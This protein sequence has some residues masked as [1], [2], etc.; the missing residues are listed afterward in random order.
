MLSKTNGVSRAWPAVSGPVSSLLTLVKHRGDRA[1]SR[2]GAWTFRG[3]PP[4]SP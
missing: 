1:G 2:Q 3:K 4:Y